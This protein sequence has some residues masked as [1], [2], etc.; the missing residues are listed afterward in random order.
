MKYNT[1]LRASNVQKTREL[2]RQGGSAG[3]QISYGL[4][5]VFLAL[6]LQVIE[7]C[8]TNVAGVKFADKRMYS[9]RQVKKSL[10]VAAE[11]TAAF[12]SIQSDWCVHVRY[13]EA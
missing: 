13:V 9:G 5:R 12:P 3:V 8:R 11:K 4:S 6:S 1:S 2:C 10:G 7:R